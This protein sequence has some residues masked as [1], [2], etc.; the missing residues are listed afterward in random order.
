MQCVQRPNVL[1]SA[2]M[3]NGNHTQTIVCRLCCDRGADAAG[4]VCCPRA[5]GGQGTVTLSAGFWSAKG[6]PN[7]PR[8]EETCTPLPHTVQCR[9]PSVP[10]HQFQCALQRVHC[11]KLLHR[12]LAPF[13][14]MPQARRV[15]FTAPVREALGSHLCSQW[16]CAHTST[17]AET[18]TTGHAI[19]GAGASAKLRW[20]TGITWSR[21]CA[22][23]MPSCRQ[24][25]E[26]ARVWRCTPPGVVPP[27][28]RPPSEVS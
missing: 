26:G 4:W 14:L 22:H 3:K 5:R 15:R 27:R 24:R 8:E 18:Q 17:N 12:F 23:G 7:P 9:E 13:W 6:S 1:R 11:A 19:V 10:G 20:V 16:N 28:R 2:T 25:G 21:C